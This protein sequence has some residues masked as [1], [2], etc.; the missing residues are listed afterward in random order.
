MQETGDEIKHLESIAA[1][2]DIASS[3]EDLVQIKEEMME[4]GYVKRKNTGGKKVKSPLVHT[5]IFPAMDMIS[6]SAK[7]IFRTMSFLLSLLP[8]MTGG[9]MPKDSRDPM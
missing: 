8:A 6:M 5:I 4:Y 2:L 1:S 3:E 9:S 7:I